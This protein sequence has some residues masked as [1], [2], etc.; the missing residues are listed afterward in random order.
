METFL[1]EQLRMIEGMIPQLERERQA[2]VAALEGYKRVQQGVPLNVYREATSNQHNESDQ[3][4]EVSV[5][6]EAK[7]PTFL[8]IM[9][10]QEREREAEK[11]EGEAREGE[12]RESGVVTFWRYHPFEACGKCGLWNHTTSVHGKKDQ[13]ACGK[14]KREGRGTWTNH[15]EDEHPWTEEISCVACVEAEVRDVR[16][17]TSECQGVRR[18]RK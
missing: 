13:P 12:R 2:I 6:Q 3:S 17:T 14:C 8:E 9:K 18:F 5:E 15:Q 16:H 11:M 1:R 7:A 10:E 4:K